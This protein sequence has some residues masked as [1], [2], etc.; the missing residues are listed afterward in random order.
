MIAVCLAVAAAVAAVAAEDPLWIRG[1]FAT[2]TI[3]NDFSSVLAFG[4]VSMHASPPIENA[5]ASKS[6]GADISLG[7]Y[8]Q[9]TI[10]TY[11]IRYYEASDAFT[12][13]RTYPLPPFVD[14]VSHADGAAC[15]TLSGAYNRPG[16]QNIN[17][18]YNLSPGTGGIQQMISSLQEQQWALDQEESML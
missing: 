14:K 5:T 11:V 13:Q 7:A 2:L 18:N 17:A 16:K 1:S 6:S 8:D 10:G 9:L 4:P 12:F 3:K 15:P